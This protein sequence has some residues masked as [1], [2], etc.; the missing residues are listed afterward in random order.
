MIYSVSLGTGGYSGWKLLNR[1]LDRQRDIFLQR[2]STSKL[3]NHFQDNIAKVA[4]AEEF[5]GD[6]K[7]MKVALGAFGLDDKLAGKSFIR[8]VLEAD[9]NDKG[10]FANR[11]LDKRYLKLNQALSFGAA[12]GASQGPDHRSILEDY[13][14]RSF[15]QSIGEQHEELE[16]ALNAR[17]ELSE[18]S[19]ADTTADS[20]WYQVMA[21]S[22]LRHVFETA[23]GLGN[24]FAALPIDRQLSDLS[25]KTEKL[26]GSSDVAIF[27]SAENV[28][29]LIRTFLLR[30]QITSQPAS[31]PYSVALAVLRVL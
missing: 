7:L 25:R 24:R 5:V 16:Y 13:D 17:R 21:S 12:A 27:K 15:A 23:F 4:S 29:K 28:E 18:I 8:K 11:L 30:N 19:S 22:T 1:S 14:S 26:T 3:R 2:P 6:Y 10:S 9:P 31:S 20:K